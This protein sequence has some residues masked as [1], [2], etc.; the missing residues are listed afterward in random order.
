[1]QGT[2]DLLSLTSVPG[3]MMENILLESISKHMKEKKVIRIRQPGFVVVDVSL[4]KGKSCLI[5]IM[6]LAFYNEVP[7][8]VGEWRGVDVVYQDFS[9]MLSP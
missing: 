4:F 7:S 1:M 2:K 3:K 6:L 8:V 9:L 5:L